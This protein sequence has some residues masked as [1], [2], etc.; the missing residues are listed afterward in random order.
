MAT[1]FTSG[2]GPD[3]LPRHISS[4]YFVPETASTRDDFCGPCTAVQSV[5]SSA[6]SSEAGLHPRGPIPH[7]KGRLI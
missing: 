5:S 3:P 2:D 1:S 4:L 6:S 7:F